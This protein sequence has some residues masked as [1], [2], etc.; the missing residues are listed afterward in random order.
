MTKEELVKNLKELTDAGL[1][2]LL[3]CIKKEM[4]NRSSVIRHDSRSPTEA[5]IALACEHRN[6]RDPN[7]PPGFSAN[8]E[9][10]YTF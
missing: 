9:D 1:N 3:K 10:D 6:Y 4:E 2:E 7:P 5:D 8:D